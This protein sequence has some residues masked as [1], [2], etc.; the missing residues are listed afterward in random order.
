MFYYIK[1][2]EEHKMLISSTKLPK[3]MDGVVL[4]TKEEYLVEQAKIEEASAQ[5]EVK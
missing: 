3:N 2:N 4:I 1:Q 5:E